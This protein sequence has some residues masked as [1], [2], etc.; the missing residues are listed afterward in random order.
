MHCKESANAIS[1]PLRGCHSA[2]IPVRFRIQGIDGAAEYST[3]TFCISS[4]CFVMKTPKPLSVGA[5]LSLRLR[6][7]TH[8]WGSPLCEMNVS[9]RVA[10]EERLDDGTVAYKVTIEQMGRRSYLFT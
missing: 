9:G 7:L 6:V 8:T 1:K 10:S 5:V 2:T 3:E 4:N